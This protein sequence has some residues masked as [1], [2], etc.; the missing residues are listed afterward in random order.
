MF[1]IVRVQVPVTQLDALTRFLA[2]E[3]RNRA[4]L[5]SLVHSLFNP[6][7]FSAASGLEA[8]TMGRGIAQDPLFFGTALAGGEALAQLL[9]AGERAVPRM[10]A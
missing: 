4:I 7:G 1:V 2:E 8:Q 10:N 3:A 5:D 6:E 9:A